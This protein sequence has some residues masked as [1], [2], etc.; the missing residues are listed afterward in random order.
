MTTLHEHVLSEAPGSTRRTATVRLRIVP[1]SAYHD[2]RSA[3][4]KAG[5]LHSPEGGQ[6]RKWG[7][8]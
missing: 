6:S 5:A 4:K 2:L 8:V 1:G 3:I 7:M